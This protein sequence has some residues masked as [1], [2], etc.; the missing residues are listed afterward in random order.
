M[1]LKEFV[2]QTFKQI[3]DGVKAAQSH[4]A[5]EGARINPAGKQFSPKSTSREVEPRVDRVEFDIALVEENEK[6]TKG[7]LGVYL[8]S[9]G[10]GA[11]TQLDK[12]VSATTRVRFS[13]RFSPPVQYSE[14]KNP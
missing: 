13:I 8:G 14:E 11:Q 3:I 1:E 6:Q 7:G 10:M 12:A 2:E 4:A 9:F 5:K